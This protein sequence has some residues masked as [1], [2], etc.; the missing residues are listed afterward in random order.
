MKWVVKFRSQFIGGIIV[1]MMV[2]MECAKRHQLMSIND[3]S[4]CSLNV[5]VHIS[6]AH[7]RI[8]A[9]TLN[10]KKSS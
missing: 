2:R 9:D 1:M 10:E 7:L 4:D 5:V 6:E 8:E 3:P